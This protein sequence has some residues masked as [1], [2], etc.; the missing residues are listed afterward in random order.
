VVVVSVDVEYPWVVLVVV[1]GG[2]SCAAERIALGLARVRHAGLAARIRSV[3]VMTRS[4]EWKNCGQL[5]SSEFG[6][7]LEARRVKSK[8]FGQMALN[9][10]GLAPQTEYG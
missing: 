8:N 9:L 1:V 5:S 7:F 3:E 10:I 6:D 2:G 4:A